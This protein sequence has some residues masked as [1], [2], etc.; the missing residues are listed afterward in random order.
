MITDKLLVLTKNKTADYSYYVL[1]ADKVLIEI[2]QTSEDSI[3]SLKIGKNE[4]VFDLIAEA[5]L[6]ADFENFSDSEGVSTHTIAPLKFDNYTFKYSYVT[7]NLG[8][9][10]S[11]DLDIAKYCN[12]SIKR[13]NFLTK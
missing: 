4:I 12:Q 1:L 5:L 8:D 9:I 3:F 10:V 6:V 7:D 11:I 13:F 2:M